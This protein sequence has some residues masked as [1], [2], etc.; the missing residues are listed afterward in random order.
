M[1]LHAQC[2]DDCHRGVTVCSSCGVILNAYISDSS[3]D[4]P[5]H[6]SKAAVTQDILRLQ[7]TL[8]SVNVSDV[9][10]SKVKALY[11]RYI[12]ILSGNSIIIK[13]SNRNALIV[14]SI[15]ECI[16]LDPTL[17]GHFMNVFKVSGRHINAVYTKIHECK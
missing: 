12:L 17:K 16:Q 9:Y 13:A 6:I 10:V 14:I 8:A 3:L 11:I 15:F 7:N 1:C 2:V 5:P 4:I